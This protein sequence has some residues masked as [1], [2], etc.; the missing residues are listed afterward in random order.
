ME[1]GFFLDICTESMDDSGRY[2]SPIFR[3]TPSIFS[4]GSMS[5]ECAGAVSPSFSLRKV[6]SVADVVS[7]NFCICAM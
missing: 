7:R 3:A 4:G 1:S 6:I 2:L 5:I